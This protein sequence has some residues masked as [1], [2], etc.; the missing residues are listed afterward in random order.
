M[1]RSQRT[2]ASMPTTF[3]PC[4]GHGAQASAASSLLADA[5][6]PEE[7]ATFRHVM[8][9]MRT[10]LQPAHAAANGLTLVSVAALLAEAWFP[11]LPP[12]GAAGERNAASTVLA[13]G[14]RSPTATRPSQQRVNK[15][16]VLGD[17]PATLPHRL[18]RRCQVFGHVP[19]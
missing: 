15:T 10:A 5:L 18:G 19:R 6:A 1:T 4:S 8:T 13:P 3:K 17:H 12:F 16:H 11:P 9:L 14:H 7:W 2:I